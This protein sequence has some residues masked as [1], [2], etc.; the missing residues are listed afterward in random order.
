MKL[1]EAVDLYIAKRQATGEKLYSPAAELRAFSR[2]YGAVELSSVTPDQVSS[3]L[4][5]PR[6]GPAT[7]RHKYGTLR[8]FFEHWRLREELH[9]IPLPASPPKYTSSFV[10]YIYSVSELRRLLDFVPCCQQRD[11]C[12]MSAPTFRALLLLLYGTGMRIGEA[13]RLH[14]GDVNLD[15]G[16]I[17]IRGTKFYKSRLVPLGSDVHAQLRSYVALPGRLD[18]NEQPLFQSRLRRAVLHQTV[19]DSFQRLRSLAGIRREGPSVYQP[20]IHDLRHTF[21]VHRLTEWYR[22]GADVQ[23]LLPALSTYLGHVEL[24]ST[25][26]YLTMTPE[27]LGEANRRFER[28]VCGGGDER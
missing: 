9:T 16:V 22:N 12:M 10:P 4:S 20:R 6:T 11:A 28:Y 2:S 7:W 5:G 14:I 18:R 24:H 25:Q 1:S 3:F 15:A 26:R 27:L 17:T 8:V 19:E 21:A 13:L 23:A